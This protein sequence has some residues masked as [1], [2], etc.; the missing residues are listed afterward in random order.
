MKKISNIFRYG[1]MVAFIFLTGCATTVFK[2]NFDTNAIGQSPSHNQE[3]GTAD[4]SG[5]VVVVGPPALPSGKWV[6]IGRS[7][8]RPGQSPSPLG[9]FQGNFIRA[10]N[11]GIYTFSTVLYIPS[12]NS[13]VATIQFDKFG[14]PVSDVTQGFLHID[15]MPDNTVRIDDKDNTKFGQ[16]P[17]NQVFVVQVTLNINPTGRCA[18]RASGRRLG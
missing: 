14:W 12:G 11:P 13:N 5:S 17:R 2:S 18:H 16:F 4:V 8:T 1:S 9:I 15:F 10:Q 6:E 3:V 7:A